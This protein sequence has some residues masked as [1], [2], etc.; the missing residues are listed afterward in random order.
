MPRIKLTLA[1][2]GTAYHG[3]QIQP[4]QSSIQGKL[5]AALQKLTQETI[6]IQGA[7]RTDA[8]VHALGQVAHFDTASSFPAHEWIRALNA[9]L[10][11]DI[12][13]HDVAK[14]DREFHARFSAKEKEYRYQ[15]FNAKQPAPLERQ[16]RWFV[17]YVLDVG[18]MEEAAK[19]LRGSHCFTSFCAT[20]TDVEDHN[21]DLNQI[22]IVKKGE[23]IDII[24]RASR[25]LRYMVRNIV[26]FLVEVGRGKRFPEEVE[27][28]LA[29]MDRRA[30]GLTAPSHGLILVKVIYSGG[31]N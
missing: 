27:T 5:E 6:R 15:I 8:G 11:E 4:Q 21:I 7:G 14:V 12:V 17:R 26:G 23:Q 3:W 13:V 2:D 24:F 25:F 19:A 9:V 16:T 1:Y 22:Q 31:Q 10:P 30:A 18:K 20:D 29:A 28:I